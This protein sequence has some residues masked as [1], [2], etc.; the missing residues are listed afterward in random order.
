MTIPSILTA[1]AKK[2]FQHRPVQKVELSLDR[3]LEKVSDVAVLMRKTQGKWTESKAL[4]H[5]LTG[6]RRGKVAS[7]DVA[8]S[9]GTNYFQIKDFLSGDKQNIQLE[10]MLPGPGTISPTSDQ[11]RSAMDDDM[12]EAD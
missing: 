12:D 8:A 1:R 6:G 2:S 9:T 7:R 3:S 10:D 11:M 4:V 5:S